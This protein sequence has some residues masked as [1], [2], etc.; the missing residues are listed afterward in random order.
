MVHSPRKVINEQNSASSIF[1]RQQWADSDERVASH[2]TSQM[3]KLSNGI[4]SHGYVLL[5]VIGPFLDHMHTC[6]S[7]ARDTRARHY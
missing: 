5:I 3:C 1:R 6:L 2:S 4:N 7:F